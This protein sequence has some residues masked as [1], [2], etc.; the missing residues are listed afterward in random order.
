MTEKELKRL[1]KL[2]IIDILIDVVCKNGCLLLNILQKPDGTIDDDAEFILKKLAEWFKVCGEAVYSTRPWRVFSEGETFVK[3]EGFREDK[4]DWTPGD[5]RFVQKDGHVYAFLMGAKGGETLAVR[6][7]GDQEI[8]S[9][10]LLGCGQL[11]HKQEFGVLLVKLPDR[12][13][14]F[15]ANVLKIRI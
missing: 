5:L 3:I 15:C 7:F 13:P 4:T 11:E 12:L 8:R 2:E 1:S 9:V 14:M 10:E 6:S